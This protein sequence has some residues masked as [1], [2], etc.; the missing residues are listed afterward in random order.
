MSRFDLKLAVGGGD[1]EDLGAQ[2]L[3]LVEVGR[4]P[5]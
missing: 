3:K 2:E 5:S 1:V 4:I